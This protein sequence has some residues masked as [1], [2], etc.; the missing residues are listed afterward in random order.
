MG[1]FSLDD[2]TCEHKNT[3]SCTIQEHPA[4]VIVDP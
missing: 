4:L 1:G 3:F 2:E